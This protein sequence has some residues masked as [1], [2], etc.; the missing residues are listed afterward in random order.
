MYGEGVGP[1]PGE[2]VSLAVPSF[3]ALP[4][5]AGLGPHPTPSLTPIVLP[6]LSSVPPNSLLFLSTPRGGRGRDGRKRGENQLLS[7]FWG[8]RG[9]PGRKDREGVAR[10]YFGRGEGFSCP[11]REGSTV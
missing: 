4:S 11:K 1:G 6:A 10:G 7:Q 9:S 5:S 2:E 8:G 3:P